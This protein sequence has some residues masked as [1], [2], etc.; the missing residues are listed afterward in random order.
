MAL[1]LSKNPD[2]TPAEI[3]EILETTAVHLPNSSSPKG[4][5]FGSGR[6]N[7]LTAVETVSGCGGPISN[8]AYVLNYDKIVNVTWNKPASFS[9]LVGYNIYINGMVVQEIFTEESYTFQASEEGVY[10]ICIVAIHHTEEG[11]CESVE[12]CLN[13]NVTDICDPVTDLDATVEGYTVNLSWS[14]P[15]LVSEVLH[16]NIY[17]ND[18]FVEAVETETFSEETLAGNYTYYVEVE[19]INECISDKVSIDVRVLAAPANLTATPQTGAIEL[20]W[21]Y[22]DNDVLFNIYRDEDKYASNIAGKQF[23]DTEIIVDIDYCYYVKAA[24]GENE[25]AASDE[26]CTMVV[27]IA[28]YKSSLKVYPNPANSIINIEGEQIEKITIHNSLG[29]IVKVVP[30]I[31]QITSINI[32]NFA[33]GNYVFSVLYL[34]NSTENIKVVIK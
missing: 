9:N 24:L 30:V 11:D 27:G 16:Y 33:A 28:E 2:L 29:Q 8:L 18:D 15:E 17:R 20:A 19:Y 6:I 13:I 22:A 21:E 31:D 26:A 3:C 4:N 23:T 10:G 32:S 5:T 25:S 34:D 12:R 1:M 14:T 7:A